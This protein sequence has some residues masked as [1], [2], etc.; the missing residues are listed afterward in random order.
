[1]PASRRFPPSRNALDGYQ[2]RS[3]AQATIAAPTRDTGATT[4]KSS[5]TFILRRRTG[6]ACGYPFH[7]DRT[8]ARLYLSRER[9]RLYVGYFSS[10]AESALV[11]AE[12]PSRPLGRS[13]ARR[14]RCDRRR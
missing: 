13:A 11:T 12:A 10:Y 3:W 7:R 6:R 5:V 14:R 9:R 8:P 4:A 2:R 1:M